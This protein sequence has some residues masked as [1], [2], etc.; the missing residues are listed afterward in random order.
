MPV[1]LIQAKLKRQPILNY[2]K[3][4]TCY[5]GTRRKVLI[6]GTRQV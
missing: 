4:V 5:V 2:F 3:K 1:K 6:T